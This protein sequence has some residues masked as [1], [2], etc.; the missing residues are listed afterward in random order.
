MYS[1]E[2]ISKIAKEILDSPKTLENNAKNVE[3]TVPQEEIDKAIE[4]AITIRQKIDSL[5]SEIDIALQDLNGENKPS[6]LESKEDFKTLTLRLEQ[7]KK[8]ITVV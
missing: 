7:I 8:K 1:L 3:T 5:S 4:I 2:K 6:V